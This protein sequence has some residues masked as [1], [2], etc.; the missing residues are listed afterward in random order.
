ME[1][2]LPLV[3]LADSL[4]LA[5]HEVDPADFDEAR[6]ADFLNNRAKGV[7]YRRKDAGRRKK[8]LDAKRIMLG[9]DSRTRK[10]SRLFVV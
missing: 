7:R 10:K 1:L 2:G 3:A 4:R 5:A 6:L 9:P 8:K